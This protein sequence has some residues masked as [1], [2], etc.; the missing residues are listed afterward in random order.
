MIYIF[1]DTKIR[2]AW[3]DPEGLEK[4]WWEPREEKERP[5]RNSH[6]VASLATLLSVA[7]FLRFPCKPRS[8]GQLVQ[9]LR[10]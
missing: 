10:R 3:L 7:P 9:R 8:C 2:D 1:E 5:K 4:T 6:W